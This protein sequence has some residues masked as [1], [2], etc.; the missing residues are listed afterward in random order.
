MTRDS[1]GL[2]FAPWAPIRQA[3]Q[4]CDDDELSRT[5]AEKMPEVVVTGSQNVGK[6]AFMKHISGIDV[7]PEEQS[8][9]TRAPIEVTSKCIPGLAQ[10]EAD[11][12]VP[13]SAP[14]VRASSPF[15]R[16]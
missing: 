2:R 16:Q 15:T 13:G 3:L 7:F 9:A 10:P 4:G 1:A 12:F 5:C 14:M 6:S 8:L 11:L